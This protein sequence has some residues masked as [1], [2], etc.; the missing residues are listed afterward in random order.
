MKVLIVTCKTCGEEL[1]RTK[2]LPDGVSETRALVGATLNCFCS[3]SG[4]NSGSD[5]NLNW[6]SHWEPVTNGQAT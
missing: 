5:Y 2:P 6:E 3:N 1:N 4:H